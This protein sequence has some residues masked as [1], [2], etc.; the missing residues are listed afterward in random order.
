[1]RRREWRGIKVSHGGFSTL[2]DFE[3]QATQR[4][5]LLLENL[6]AKACGRRDCEQLMWRSGHAGD[7]AKRGRRCGWLRWWLPAVID[8]SRGALQ[9][10]RDDGRSG[11]E[12]ALPSRCVWIAMGDM[13]VE[14]SL[15]YAVR[16]WS[17]HSPVASP[18]YAYSLERR[19]NFETHNRPQVAHRRAQTNEWTERFPFFR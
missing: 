8:A 1:M 4:L 17:S 15:M 13:R 2:D 3:Q 12:V 6:D 11:V 5:S 19:H 10:Y 16:A 18:L 14:W 9:M 7:Y